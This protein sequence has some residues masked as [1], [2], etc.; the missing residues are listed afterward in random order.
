MKN[1]DGSPKDGN[2]LDSIK[3]FVVNRDNLLAVSPRKRRDRV[4]MII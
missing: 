4:C 3:K 2:I 1:N